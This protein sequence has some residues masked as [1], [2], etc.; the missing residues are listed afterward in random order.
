M[1]YIFVTLVLLTAYLAGCKSG[2][3]KSG[4]VS[5]IVHTKSAGNKAKLGDFLTLHLQYATSKDSVIFSSYK[6][7]RPLSFK[8]QES[9]FKGVLNEC[10]VNM[11]PGDSATVFTPI[12]SIYGDKLP[13]FAK[14]GDIIKYTISLQKVQTQEEYTKEREDQRRKQNEEDKKIINDYLAAK[15]LTMEETPSGLRYKIDRQGKGSLVDKNAIAKMQYSIKLLNGTEV[16]SVK[17][18]TD[19]Y[20]DRQPMGMREAISMLQ[21]GGKGTFL[22]PSTL[23]YGDK[24]RGN[25]PPNSILEYNLEIFDIEIGKGPEQLRGTQPAKLEALT[26]K[27]GNANQQN[28]SQEQPTKEDKKDK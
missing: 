1:R 11:A 5:Y 7:N 27:A 3:K 10:L 15:N 26:P 20:I 24:Q 17:S 4:G 12:D 23:A 2:M 19:I 6:N 28:A 8:F 14:K 25:I 21:K 13:V 16:E 22:I 18:T 9:L